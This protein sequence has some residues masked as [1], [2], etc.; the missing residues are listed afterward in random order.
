MVLKV[1][2]FQKKT[3]VVRQLQRQSGKPKPKQKLQPSQRLKPRPNPRLKLQP[4]RLC[5]KRG[6]SSWRPSLNLSRGWRGRMVVMTIKERQKSLPPLI[7][8]RLLLV[9]KFLQGRQW[10]WWL[11]K[12]GQTHKGQRK[13]KCRSHHR[14]HHQIGHHHQHPWLM[15]QNP[16]QALQVPLHHLL[17]QMQHQRL[18]VMSRVKK[19]SLKKSLHLREQNSSPLA[20]SRCTLVS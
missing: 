2:F 14:H 6:G 3:L 4:Y 10:H 5:L 7:L 8:I 11:K 19:M 15:I 16:S 18:Q 20:V 13:W 1:V 17:L 12:S 9:Q